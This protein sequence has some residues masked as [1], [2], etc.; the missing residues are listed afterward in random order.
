MRTVRYETA[1]NKVTENYRMA[2]AEG[3]LS[4]ILIP[5]D[6]TPIE[7]KEKLRKHAEKAEAARLKKKLTAQNA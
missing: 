4:T 6:E 3:I 5:V 7:V 2:K 1:T